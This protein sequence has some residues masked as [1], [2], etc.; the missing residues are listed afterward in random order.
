MNELTQQ[1]INALKAGNKLQARRLLQQAVQADPNDL[2]GWLWLA[3]TVDGRAERMDCLRQALRI[4]PGNALALRALAE[5]EQPPA[6]EPAAPVLNPAPQPKAKASEPTPDPLPPS[7]PAAQKAAKNTKPAQP[8]S[9]RTVR[10]ALGLVA[11]LVVASIGLGIFLVSQMRAAPPLAAAAEPLA[12]SEIAGEPIAAAPG[13][14]SGGGVTATP[15]MPTPLPTETP[16]PTFTP[17]PTETFVPLGDTVQQKRARIQEQVSAIRG[18]TGQ[19]DVP[20]NIVS[21]DRTERYLRNQY[22]T[23]AFEAETE[24]ERSVLVALGLVSPGYDVTM[25][26]FNRMVDALGGFYTPDTKQIFVLGLRFGAV[27]H[28]IY[29]HEYTHA[30][31]DQNFFITDL[32]A[33]PSCATNNEPCAAL[34]A[35]AEGDAQM[36]MEAWRQKHAKSA[37]YRDITLYRPPAL[38]LL[39]Q[40]PPAYAS[41][42]NRFGSVRG[43]SFV[44]YL[45]NL[46]GWAKVSNA[47]ANPPSTS[48]Q[49]MHPKKYVSGEGA[50]SV[51]PRPL[52]EA[53]GDDWSV[54][55]QNVLGEW[56]TY[57]LLGFGADPS[58]HVDT[59][60]ASKAAAG[61]GGDSLTVLQNSE[62]QTALTVHWAWDDE[63]EAGEFF[64]VLFEHMNERYRGQRVD[65]ISGECWQGEQ[66]SCIY[67]AGSQALWLQAPDT[68]TIDLMHALYPE[69]P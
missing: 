12:Q 10:L 61:W 39:E 55:R 65:N 37:E 9:K 42:N 6:P 11:L 40:N 19:G 52:Q 4:D 2:Q 24:R 35:L 29:A 15:A 64:P 47:Y 5:L 34:A 31:L 49:I 57:L 41:E 67:L 27:E 69:F 58:A 14:A 20:F 33:A 8:V 17:A 48:E 56:Y 18:L 44:N 25:N 22:L 46:G 43:A 59:D 28:Y 1:G 54:L 32:S 45:F 3:A 62:G 68:A 66:V 50:L 21:R 30:L 36:T 51:P 60:R 16:R 38:A 13:A 23:P 53:L 63:K 26:R 7:V